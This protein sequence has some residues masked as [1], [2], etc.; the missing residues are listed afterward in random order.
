MK[1]CTQGVCTQVQALPA[2][3]H[4]RR[5]VHTRRH[6]PPPPPPLPTHHPASRS[7][8][9]PVSH[10]LRGVAVVLIQRTVV[11]GLDA[12]DLDVRREAGQR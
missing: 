12:H 8:A 7:C 1:G 6:P 9:S 3:R 10:V 11:A 5:H 4:A 2:A